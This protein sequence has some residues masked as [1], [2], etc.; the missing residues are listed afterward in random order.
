MVT[1]DG[2]RAL[3][4]ARE[5]AAESRSTYMDRTVAQLA[6]GFAHLR[7]GDPAAAEVAFAEATERVDATGDR[8]MQ[9]VVRLAHGIGLA[10]SES[11]AAEEPLSEARRRLD[12]MGIQAL[13]WDR[14]FRSAARA[15]APSA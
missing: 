3:E 11:A 9:A 7:L 13:G 8:V 5:V 2:A 15:A 6:E 14:I 1:G 10:S 4:A 12:S